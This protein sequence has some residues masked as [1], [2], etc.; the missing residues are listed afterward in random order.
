MK[1]VSDLSSN[2]QIKTRQRCSCFL[3]LKLAIGKKKINVTVTS[4]F[5]CCWSQQNSPTILHTSYLAFITSH[6]NVLTLWPSHAI[7][8]NLF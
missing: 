2:I 8:E 5:K 4:P 3:A 7:V 6:E 1:Q